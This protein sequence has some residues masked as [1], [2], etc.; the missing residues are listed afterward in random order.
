MG[1]DFGGDCMDP[2]KLESLLMD[3]QKSLIDREEFNHEKLLNAFR[4]NCAEHSKHVNKRL[5]S[6]VKKFVEHGKDIE[7]LK[8][9]QE[10]QNGALK[11]I[12]SDIKGIKETDIPEIKKALGDLKHEY[13]HGR[14]SWAVVIILGV[15]VTVIGGFLGRIIS[16]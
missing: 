12:K 3:I 11:D 10:T 6:G 2:V 5:E 7:A 4:V 8:K 1:T 13:L 9:W 15:A 14:P 16:L